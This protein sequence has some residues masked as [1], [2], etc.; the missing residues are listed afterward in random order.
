[1]G[2][3]PSTLI[4]SDEIEQYAARI[5]EGQKA[6]FAVHKQYANRLGQLKLAPTAGMIVDYRGSSPLGFCWLVRTQGGV[7]YTISQRRVNRTA[8]PITAPPPISCQ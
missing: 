6:F 3:S 7:W 1:M 2:V 4:S 8:Q 5:L